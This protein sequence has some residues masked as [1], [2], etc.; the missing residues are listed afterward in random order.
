MQSLELAVLSTV[1]VPV[2]VYVSMCVC[3]VYAERHSRLYGF[4][5]QQW[6]LLYGLYMQIG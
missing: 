2:Y 1:Y 3:G 6:K 5:L 4:V